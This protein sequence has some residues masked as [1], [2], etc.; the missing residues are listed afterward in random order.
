MKPW[1]RDLEQIKVRRLPVLKRRYRRLM[2]QQAATAFIGQGDDAA[3]VVE[4][5]DSLFD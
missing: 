3:G 4:E 5:A 2:R 1:P